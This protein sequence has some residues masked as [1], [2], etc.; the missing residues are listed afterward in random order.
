MSKP[1]KLDLIFD[2]FEECIPRI[3]QYREKQITKYNAEKSTEYGG[4]YT[5]LEKYKNRVRII[6]VFLPA[7]K[8][9]VYNWKKEKITPRDEEIN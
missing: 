5:K 7:L 8:K 9:L 6:D 3:E 4:E 1:E 2:A